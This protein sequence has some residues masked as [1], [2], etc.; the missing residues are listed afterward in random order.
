MGDCSDLIREIRAT[1][2]GNRTD[3]WNYWELLRD[4]VRQMGTGR[5]PEDNLLPLSI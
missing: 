5:M 1:G 2:V 3:F 4:V